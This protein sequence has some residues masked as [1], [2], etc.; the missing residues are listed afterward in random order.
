MKTKRILKWVALGTP[1]FLLTALGLLVGSSYLEHRSLVEQEK[2]EYP[3]PGVLVD[4]DGNKLHVYAEGRGD[5]TLVFLSGF[6]TTSPFY[7]FKPLY[8]RL[9][10]DYRVAVVERAGYG[11]SDVTSDARDIDTV[12]EATRS[13]LEL[14]GEEGPYVLFP[15]S[16]AGLEAAHWALRYPEE[17]E[18]IIGLD[19]LV[20]PY[21]QETELQPSVSRMITVLTRT[22]LIRNQPGVFESNFTAMQKG[23]LTDAEAEIART[24]F[25]RRVLTKNMWEEAEALPANAETVATSGTPEVPVHAFVSSRN[26]DQQWS[27]SIISYAGATGGEHVLLDGHHYIHLDYPELIADKSRELIE[28]TS[29]G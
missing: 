24:I 1:L 3:A 11:W 15:H 17:V 5:K 18:A 9:A 23:H 20:P 6:G 29:E 26:E 14:A 25:F 28:G 22:G 8:E 21:A 2:H 19:A 4:V 10:S 7:D 27:E 12:L 16:M 13:A